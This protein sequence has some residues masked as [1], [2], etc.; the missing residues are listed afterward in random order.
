MDQSCRPTSHATVHSTSFPQLPVSWIIIIIILKFSYFC[1]S[2]DKKKSLMHN[3]WCFETKKQKEETE[4]VSLTVWNDA[5]QEAAARLSCCVSILTQ[6]SRSDSWETRSLVH[7]YAHSL[8]ADIRLKCRQNHQ[9]LVFLAQTNRRATLCLNKSVKT[10]TQSLPHRRAH[11]L[12]LKETN[13]IL[14]LHAHTQK[15]KSHSQCQTIPTF[16]SD[17]APLHPQ[18]KACLSESDAQWDIH[19]L[20][21][22]VK[23]S[24][25]LDTRIQ[26]K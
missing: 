13:I 8:F 19:I 17:K 3:S 25:H 23:Y 26:T 16:L 12:S 24:T 18:K 9:T 11:F 6:R 14:F 2:W 1:C 20:V 10:Q 21:S 15:K 22:P 4:S 7:V 5:V